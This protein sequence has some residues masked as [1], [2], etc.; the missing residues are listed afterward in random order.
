MYI[1][2]P[3]SGMPIE[4]AKDIFASAS[5]EIESAGHIPVNPFDSGLDD[6]AA[7][8]EHMKAD[9]RMM[10]DCDAIHML[11]GWEHSRGATIE[12]G[13]AS[14]LGFKIIEFGKL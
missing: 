4:L 13:L 6:S 2:G 3:I 1:S 14:A 7:W 12:K 9:L 5:K 11:P 10:L 8:Q